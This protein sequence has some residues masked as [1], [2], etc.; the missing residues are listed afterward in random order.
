MRRAK[1]FRQAC[2]LPLRERWAAGE[3]RQVGVPDIFQILDAD[4]AGKKPI[5]SEVTQ[6]GEELYSGP[7]RGV[8]PRILAVGDLVKHFFLLG[9]RAFQEYLSATVM[10]CGIQ[11]G[12]APTQGKLVFVVLAGQQID[13][14]RRARFQ[15]ACSFL[16]RGNNRLAE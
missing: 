3:F 7:Q 6:E 11:P 9:R 8:V 10:A 14:L 15:S 12:K 13:K 1:S 2:A 5:R 4:F 16:V